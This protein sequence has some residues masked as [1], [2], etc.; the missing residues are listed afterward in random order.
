MPFAVPV[1]PY[2]EYDP[3]ESF[4]TVRECAEVLNITEE[5]V[6]ELANRLRSAAAMQE[7]DRMTFPLFGDADL[8]DI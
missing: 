6:R 8:D 4:V 3:R 5:Q 7:E 1:N 2:A